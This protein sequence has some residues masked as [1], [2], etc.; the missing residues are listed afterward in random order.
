MSWSR[1]ADFK[2]QLQRLWDRG[3]IL[4]EALSE[5]S[6]FPRKLAFKTPSAVEMSSRFDEVRRWIAELRGLRNCRIEFRS[7]NHRQLGKNDVPAEVWIDTVDDA[8]SWLGKRAA[9]KKFVELISL[10]AAEQPALLNWLRNNSLRAL[11]NAAAWPQVLSVV[12]WICAN[13][14]PNI[15]IREVDLAAI[16]SKFIEQNK[17]LLAELFDICLPADAIDDTA[18]GISQFAQRY[19]FK[20]ER[21]RIRFRI[22]DPKCA[23]FGSNNDQDITVDVDTFANLRLTVKRVFITENKTNFL[24]FPSV[25]DSLVIFGAGY[26]WDAVARAHGLFHCDIHYWGDIDTHGFAILNQLRAAF[27]HVRSLLMDEYT[28]RKFAHLAVEES[29][30]TDSVFESLTA[31]ESSMLALIRSGM[32]APNYRLEQ[33]RIDWTYARSHIEAAVEHAGPCEPM[34]SGL[35]EIASSDV[36]DYFRPSRCNKRLGLLEVKSK[37]LQIDPPSK[38]AVFLGEL[39]SRHRTSSLSS[40]PRV[41]DLSQIDDR[42][43]RHAATVDAITSGA[44]AIGSPLLTVSTVI[45]GE[46]VTIHAEVDLLRLNSCNEYEVVEF[47]L[48]RR[49]SDHPELAIRLS[50]FAW[51]FRQ[52]T[53]STLAALL[54]ENPHNPPIAVVPNIS[55]ALRAVLD[56]IRARSNSADHYSPVGWTKCSD[57]SFRSHC[58]SEAVS[59]KDVAILPEVDQ[60]LAI[61]LHRTGIESIDSLLTSFDRTTLSAFQYRS[62]GKTVRVGRRADPILATA[63]SFSTNM[64]IWLPSA[65]ALPQGSTIAV[66]DFEGLPP[67]TVPQEMVYLW[68][69][70]LFGEGASDYQHSLAS[71]NA[72]DGDLQA[73]LKFLTICDSVLDEHPTIQFVHYHHYE[74]TMLRKYL[75][76]YGDQNY[77]ATRVLEQ[78]VD[79]HALLRQSVYLPVHSYGLKEVERYLGFTRSQSK[80]GGDWSIAAFARAMQE[81]DIGNLHEIR[82]YNAE[83]IQATSLVLSY[84]RENAPSPSAVSL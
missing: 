82:K 74:T 69:L 19:G 9:F 3:E 46:P 21:E 72:S 37:E 12:A 65:P 51:A 53:D 15:Y 76:R 16:D 27:P 22:I 28:A 33:E 56:I 73:W 80:Y 79:L 44:A 78:C 42:A 14:R 20:F 23:L 84:L 81:E 54:I 29:K 41:I 48:A 68:G 63:R 70:Q 39:S 11:E 25:P 5:Q 61:A 40:L 4:A 66:I 32:L 10:T 60:E 47:T 13:P 55:T 24:A 18:S 77:V 43:A 45:A 38:L 49:L 50:L 59:N 71:P 1:E 7:V 2:A 17:Q 30:P 83:D 58:W 8:V 6:G 35:N 26:G 75:E 67:L 52:A 64:P 62:G 57:C 31:A 34:A 36:I